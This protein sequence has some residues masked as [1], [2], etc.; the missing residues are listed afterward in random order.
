MHRPRSRHTHT[1]H[2]A[3]NTF[4]RSIILNKVFVC[5]SIFLCVFACVFRNHKM[6][7]RKYC[8]HM[9]FF[10]F[11]FFFSTSSL[12]PNVFSFQHILLCLCVLCCA[13]CMLFY[14]LVMLI[15]PTTC[16]PAQ[17]S[18]RRSIAYSFVRYCTYLMYRNRGQF[19]SICCTSVFVR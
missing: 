14:I 2:T 17:Y 5:F 6:P 16:A 7:N 12:L 15:E 9:M 4:S 11:F 8:V 10:S 1:A 3:Y 19:S 18:V 13:V